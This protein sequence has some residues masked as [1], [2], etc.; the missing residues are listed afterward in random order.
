M[1]GWAKNEHIPFNFYNCQLKE[2][3][4]SD[5]PDYIK[6]RCRRRIKMASKFILLIGSDTHTKE[7]FVKPEVEAAI[8]KKCAIIGVNLDQ[9][10]RPSPR[11]TPSFMCNIGAIFV[12]YSPGIIQHTLATY[13]GNPDN[14][15]T[16][17]EAV[18]QREGYR[19]LGDKAVFLRP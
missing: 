9:S 11:L 14:D 16:I 2:A 15:Y 8:E 17:H 19:I 6:R 1:Q 3:I 4:K 18:Y 7:R 10:W 12:P 5:N 13:E